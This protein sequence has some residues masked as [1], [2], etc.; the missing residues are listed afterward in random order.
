MRI[1]LVESIRSDFESLLLISIFV[2]WAS[3]VV[4]VVRFL[5]IRLAVFD[6]VL[7]MYSSATLSMSPISLREPLS[8]Q[9]ALVHKDLMDAM[10]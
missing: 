3:A 6:T 8:S 4:A 5:L 9:R 1:G 10:L 7:L 2:N